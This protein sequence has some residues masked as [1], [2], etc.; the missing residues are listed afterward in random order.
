M[1]NQ[2]SVSPGGGL[3]R[4]TRGQGSGDP[5]EQSLLSRKYYYELFEYARAMDDV[6]G[7]ASGTADNV[8]VLFTGNKW[9]VIS[10]Y[11]A[12]G[13]LT[14]TFVPIV[15]TDGLDVKFEVTASE[16]GEF[17]WGVQD[18]TQ[19]R[20][21]LGFKAD[22]DR[23]FFAKLQLSVAD[24]SGSDA[25]YFGWRNA[26]AYDATFANYT[27]YAL[28]GWDG[29]DATQNVD[30]FLKG[31]TG[32][33][34]GNAY[35]TTKDFADAQTHVWEVRVN[36]GGGVTCLIDERPV[37]SSAGAFTFTSG[38]LLFPIFRYTNAA[39]GNTGA[40]I[41]KSLEIGYRARQ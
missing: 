9:G 8:N 13:T 23:D 14:D 18:G 5:R 15:A 35:D 34:T 38:M 10:E 29:T 19:V 26:G 32:N 2:K 16:G 4:G 7:A 11:A 20:Q 28:I 40:L 41:L 39:G 1:S 6:G 21:R 12:I 3:G 37:Q 31:G 36:A 24:V 25:F 17:M 27:D 30:L 33:N 22:V